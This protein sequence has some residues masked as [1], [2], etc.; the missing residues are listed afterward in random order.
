MVHGTMT[1]QTEMSS[2]LFSW[3]VQHS[4]NPLLLLSVYCLQTTFTTNRYRKLWH[5]LQQPL[6]TERCAQNDVLTSDN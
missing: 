3:Q 1:A 4:G 6:P 2:Q 5:E